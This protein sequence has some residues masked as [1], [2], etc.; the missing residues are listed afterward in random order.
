MLEARWGC[1]VSR[2]APHSCLI[3]PPPS[4]LAPKKK[5]LGKNPDVDTSFLPDRDREVRCLSAFC[6][7]HPPPSSS[8][9]EGVPN[10]PCQLHLARHFAPIFPSVD[11][12]FL[13]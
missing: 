1:E 13:H 7:A 4:E 10:A 9:L 2:V 3:A 5:K 11:C 8:T 6:G 12:S